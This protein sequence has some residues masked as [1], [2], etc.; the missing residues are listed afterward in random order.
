M[1]FYSVD[2]ET[3]NPDQSTICQIG[4]GVFEDGV[5]VETWKS[6]IDP[7][8]YFHWR[9]IEIHGITPKMVKGKPT[10]P[11]VYPLLRQMFENN[12]VVHHS[13][14]DRVAFRK[15]FE[16]YGLESFEVQWL[17]SVRVAKHT[18]EELDGGY[19]LGNLASYLDIEFHHHDALEDS[20]TCGKIV[21]EASK[22]SSIEVVRWL[23][24]INKFTNIG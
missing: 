18:W 14:F 22:K 20:I 10:F 3:A 19:N 15:A 6:Y 23:E 16:R 1:K 8:D 9:F 24:Q 11:K 2:V 13:P 7:Q 12:I 4:V 17:D 21:V 5:L